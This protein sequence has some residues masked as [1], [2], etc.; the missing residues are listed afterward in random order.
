MGK[1]LNKKDS[2]TA[3]LTKGFYQ[4]R[5][6]HAIQGHFLY[7]EVKDPADVPEGWDIYDPNPKPVQ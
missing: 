7:N 5:H 1:G 3:P 2:K 4:I 6:K